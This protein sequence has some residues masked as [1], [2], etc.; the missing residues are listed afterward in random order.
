[1]SATEAL[2]GSVDSE[3]VAASGMAKAGTAAPT[4]AT[5][6][7]PG[8]S[9]RDSAPAEEAREEARLLEHAYDGIQEFD[10]PLPGWWSW[11][12]IGSIVFSVFYAL[13]Y[14][15][16][17]WGTS[18]AQGYQVALARYDDKRE[19]REKA[20]LSN[21]T[22]D[23]LAQRAEDG[24]V[25]ARGEAVFGERC[26]SCHGPTGAGLIGPN[27]TDLAQLHGGSRLDL[28]RTV[29]GGVAGTAMLAWGE[30]LSDQD[31]IA[32]TAFVITLQGK[33]LQGKPPE[34]APVQPFAR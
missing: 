16:V 22:E 20:A 15:V 32:A 10:N 34:G 26:A 2:P 30:Q 29:R 9:A 19:I 25:L 6:T 24:K 13:Y 5:Q 18:P 14:H 17:D 11:I 28:Y 12:F 23:M 7:A 27:L 1:M 21:V 3:A 4:E 8:A 33:Q 31:V